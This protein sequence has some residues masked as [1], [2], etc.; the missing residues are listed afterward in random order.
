LSRVGRDEASANRLLAAL[1]KDSRDRLFAQSQ[2]VSLTVKDILYHRGDVITAVY[3]PLTCVISLMA[4]MQN[5]ATI[6]I[7]TVGN[8]GVVGLAAYLGIAEAVSLGITQISG[9][10]RRMSVEHVKRAAKS[11]ERFNILLQRYTHSLIMQI[12]LSGGCNSLHSAEQ[13]YTRW[14]LMMHA[15]NKVNVFAFT[16]EFLSTMLGVSRARVNIVTRTFEKA[17]LIK[18]H[19]NQITV[20]DW[21]GIE[22]ASCDCYRA[23]QEE[24][25]RVLL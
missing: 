25:G 10:A 16:Q 13:R 21:K 1:P 14:L 11:D 3:F 6:E 7:A 18:N 15:R 12:A 24:F 17:G 8:E 23:I 22:A 19:R 9:E 4:E 20:L 2:L 5:G